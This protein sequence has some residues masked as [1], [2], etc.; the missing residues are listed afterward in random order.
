MKTVWGLTGG[1]A[2]GKSTVARRL[3][4]R[5]AYVID[6]DAIARDVVAPGTDGLAA[7]VETFGTGVLLA[8]GSLDR[9]ALGA[10]VYSDAAARARLE[11]ITHPRIRQASFE[12]MLAGSETDSP[13]IVYEAALL[14]ETKQHTNFAGLVVVA[15]SAATQRARLMARDLLDATAADARIASQ[16]PLESKVAVADFVIHNDGGLDELISQTDAVFDA[17][18]ARIGAAS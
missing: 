4:Q 17:I 11:A 1:I 5:G 15:C 9:A 12:R 7:V 3:A 13:F 14:V 18:V 6:A 16:L 10:R 2:C 8:D